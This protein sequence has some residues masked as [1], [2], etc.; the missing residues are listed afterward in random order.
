MISF[1]DQFDQ[2]S[3]NNVLLDMVDQNTIY[4]KVFNEWPQ[5]YKIPI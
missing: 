4:E 1:L 5:R 3:M 2:N